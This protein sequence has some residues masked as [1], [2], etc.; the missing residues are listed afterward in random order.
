MKTEICDL[1]GIEFPIFAFTHCRD[2]AAAVSRAGGM[3]VLGA[4]A[5]TPE[6]LEIELTWIDEHCGGKPYGVDVVMPVKTADRDAGIHETKELAKQLYSMISQEHWDYV[7]KVLA[8]HGV[9]PLPEGDTGPSELGGG[10]VGEGVLGWTEA[11]G[12]PLIDVALA[13]PISLLASALGPPPKD[14]IDRAHS[15]GVKVAALIGRLE[16]AIRDVQQGVDIIIAQGYEAGGHT[17]EVAS[18]VL[19]PDVVDAVAPVPVLAAGGIGTGRQMAAAMALGAQGVWT[20]SIWLT[21]S[22]ANTGDIAMEKLL[23]AHSTDTVRSRALT[24]KPARQ[25]RTAWTEAWE[26]PESPG[27]LPMPLQFILNSKAM[28]RI[29]RAGNKELTGMPVGQIVSRMNQVRPAKD[30]IYEMVEEYIETMTKL[31]AGLQTT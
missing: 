19:V 14:A 21:V 23:A 8:D 7:D 9:P 12:S 25:L 24:G 27:T 4:L 2:V 13:H 3:G 16:Q 1:F 20:G 30:V 5:F 31:S 15:Q 10:L 29:Q 28:R 6:Q 18:M 22:E 11:S 17:G 26:A